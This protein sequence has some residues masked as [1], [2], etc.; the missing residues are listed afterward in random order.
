MKG[1]EILKVVSVILKDYQ[2]FLFNLKF[3]I[4]TQNEKLKLASF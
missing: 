2:Y 4:N 3:L 1:K